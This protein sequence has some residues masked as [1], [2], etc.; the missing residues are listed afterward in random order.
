MSTCEHC[1]NLFELPYFSGTNSHPDFV[2]YFCKVC[3][4]YLDSIEVGGHVI[5][6][7]YGWALKE[8]IDERKNAH[9]VRRSF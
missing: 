1:G 8:E 5:E 7:G 3:H 4:S 2:N 9:K 6:E